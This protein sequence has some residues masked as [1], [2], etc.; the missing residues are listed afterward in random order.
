MLK[1]DDILE[2]PYLNPDKKSIRNVLYQMVMQRLIHSFMLL[3]TK[4]FV[5]GTLYFYA[6]PNFDSIMPQVTLK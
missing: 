2:Q 1:A 3:S 4:H 6:K 5:Q